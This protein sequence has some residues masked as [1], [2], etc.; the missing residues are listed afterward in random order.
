M[1]IHHKIVK[2]RFFLNFLGRFIHRHIYDINFVTLG[3]HHHQFTSI[4]I[5]PWI[6]FI[7]SSLHM[8]ACWLIH[9]TP[10]LT[11]LENGF[12]ST[13]MYTNVGQEMDAI[14][15]GSSWPGICGNHVKLK[16]K[17][18]KLPCSLENKQIK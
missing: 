2:D 13:H 14:L 4:I 16:V 15:T 11:R 7:G 5:V 18:L 12:P 10:H 17:T 6:F 8:V 1:A 3:F 9:N